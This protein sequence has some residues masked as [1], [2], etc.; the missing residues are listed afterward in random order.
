MTQA[1]R[2]ACLA[3]A[4]CLAPGAAPAGAEDDIKAVFLFHFSS[5]VTWPPGGFDGPSGPITYC[6]LE[7]SA[8]SVALENVIRGERVGPRALRLRYVDSLAAL[9]GC[10]I[11]LVEQAGPGV[12][13][14]LSAAGRDWHTL[15]VGTH[16]DFISAGGAVALVR[17]G[18]RVGIVINPDAVAGAGLSVSAKL[19]RLATIVKN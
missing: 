11:A 3:A 14:L 19:M 4:L 15:T 16:G 17:R 1:V 2:A 7:R 8:L 9:R 6:A 12:R 10:H 5:F 13:A 18:Q